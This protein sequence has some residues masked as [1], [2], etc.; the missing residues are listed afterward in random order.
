[1]DGESTVVA[2]E[3]GLVSAERRVVEFLSSVFGFEELPMLEFSVGRLYRL[4]AGTAVIKV[5]VPTD[6]PGKRDADLPYGT[7]G[8]GYLTIRVHDFDAVMARI[9]ESE[10]T[11]LAPPHELD[12][13]RRLAMVSDPDGTLVEVIEELP[14]SDTFGVES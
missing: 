8:L 6:R 5:L 13:G 14:A 9:G 1:M 11:V 3:V 12:R 7:S 10:G 2:V 4:Q